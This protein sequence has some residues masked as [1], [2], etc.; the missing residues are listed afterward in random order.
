MSDDELRMEPRDWNKEREEEIL[1]ELRRAEERDSK[2]SKREEVLQFP[3][4]KKEPTEFP[5]CSECGED[6]NVLYLCSECHPDSPTCTKVE[7][8]EDGEL[9]RIIVECLECEK[10]IFVYEINDQA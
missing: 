10:H 6:T 3:N 7:L 1:D 9:E 4:S 8:A 5:S 2:L